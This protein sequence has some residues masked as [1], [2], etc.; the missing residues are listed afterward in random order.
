MSWLG[1]LIG[2]GL[3]LLGGIFGNQSSQQSNRETNQ[4]NMKINQMNNAF[5]AAEASKMRDWQSQ[6]WSR[7]FNLTN[8]YNTAAAQRQRLEDAGLNPYLM[9]NGGSAGT[10]VSQSGMSGAQ[11]SA[12]PPLSMQSWRPDMSF[13]GDVANIAAQA[14]VRSSQVSALGSEKN[15]ND[16]RALQ[17]L[18]DVDWSKMTEDARRALRAQ[19]VQRAELG[20]AREQQELANMKI[21]GDVMRSEL[22]LK[23]LSADAQR[24]I[25]QYLPRMQQVQ[26]MEKLAYA[27]Q[28]YAGGELSH[29][30]M[31]TEIAT[32]IVLSAEAEGKRIDNK[33]ARQTADAMIGAMNASNNYYGSY[34]GVAQGYAKGQAST[35]YLNS[36]YEMRFRN[37]GNQSYWLD[38]SSSWIRDVGNAIG[39][40]GNV[41]K[42]A[43][44]QTI[45][46]YPRN[47]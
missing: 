12:A 38:R 31:R 3:G 37:K 25:N 20:L 42:P 29:E 9:M 32:Q 30:K 13:L 14:E 27:Y 24:T 35:D 8:E 4:T 47:K 1:S 28:A 46:V 44:S 22:A 15:L 41:R 19:G 23:M 43:R 11:G 16:A 5:N 18:S 2:G 10:A 39:N 33:V 34:Y 6:E 7:Q 17:A 40:V 26:I 45:N 36:Y 21:Q